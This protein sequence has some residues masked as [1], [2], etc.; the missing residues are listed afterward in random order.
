MSSFK[1]T[2]FRHL[3][4]APPPQIPLRSAGKF[5]LL[6]YA[7]AF[8]LAQTSAGGAAAAPAWPD[9]YQARLAVLALIETLNASLL[10]SHSAT[11]TLTDWCAAHHMA[12]EPKIVAHLQRKIMKPISAEQRRTL[13]I[14]PDEPV[15]Y[16]RVELAC[17]SHVLSQADNWYVPSRLTPAMNAALQS[18]DIPF[19]RVV[20]PL[21]PRR[22]TIAVRIFWRPLPQGWEM[23]PPPA[24]RHAQ[25]LVIPP[26][27]FEHRAVLYAAGK[28]ISE[29]D[30]SY[31]AEILDFHPQQ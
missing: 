20:S 23:R 28:P 31:R 24:D 25:N 19:G 3:K 1:F 5:A 14:G 22:Q 16:R 30:E 26:L 2:R 21:Q 9:N 27:L 29:V 15:V 4:S 6:A 11:E 7:A 10:A 12:Q 8:G 18:S 13:D 17:G